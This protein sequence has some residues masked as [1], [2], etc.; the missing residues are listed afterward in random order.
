M[1]DVVPTRKQRF[2]V[3]EQHTYTSHGDGMTYTGLSG[4]T[5]DIRAICVVRY[6]G[7]Q[8]YYTEVM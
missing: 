3:V 2:H 6:D 4:Y 5:D 7:K 8:E 1:K